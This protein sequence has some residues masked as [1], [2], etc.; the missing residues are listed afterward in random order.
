MKKTVLTYGLISGAVSSVMMLLTMPFLDRIGFDQAEVLG[1][2]T[3]LASF[4]LVFFGI[5]SYRDHVAGGTLPFGR[6]FTVGILITLLSSVCYVATWQI[7]RRTLA[8]DFGEKYAAHLIERAKESGASPAEIAEKQ[9]QMASMTELMKNP[10]VDVA[11]TFLEPFP[12]GL[13]V[14]LLSAAVLRQKNGS[15]IVVPS[16]A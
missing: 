7:V 11:V 15:E 5:R 2:T 13:L 1:Y 6:A 8:P 10:V 16:C 12:I 3:L 4:L 14:T 9:R